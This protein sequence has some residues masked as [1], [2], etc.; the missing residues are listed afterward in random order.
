MLATYLVALIIKSYI[1]N[2]FLK[3]YVNLP[4]WYSQEGYFNGNK[5]V[6]ALITTIQFPANAYQI[7]VGGIL[8][9]RS[10]F[11]ENKVENIVT[12]YWYFITRYYIM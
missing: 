1:L 7:G 6:I 11:L 12:G 2:L 3:T 10:G 4:F 5:R 9:I 8:F